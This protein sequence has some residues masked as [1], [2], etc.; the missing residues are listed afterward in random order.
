MKPSLTDLVQKLLKRNKIYF[1][2]TELEFQIQSHPSYPSLHAITG[3]LDH[4]SIENV[5]AK[6]SIDSATLQQLPNHFIAQIQESE[7]QDLV[8]V[9][10]KQSAYLVYTTTDKKQI[11][12]EDEFLKKFTGIIVAV[13]KQGNNQSLL[14][15]NSK[16]KYIAFGI[17]GLFVAFL[18]FK[19]TDSVFSICHLV[20]SIIGVVVS[21]AIV[22]QELGLQ[23]S[24]GDAFCS[25]TDDQKD[26][27]AV[28]SSKGAEIIKGYKL[29]DF[30]MLYFSVLVT[31]TFIQILNP[32]LSYSISLLTIP[33]TLYSLYYQYI[34]VK[35]WCLLCLSIIGVLWLQ[36]LISVI[37]DMYITNFVLVDFVVLGIIV[38]SIWL[39][40]SFIKP[41]IL[42][43]TTLRKDK[44][45]AIKFKRNF[46][47]F[48]GML[49][50]SHQI[51]TI[52][53]ENQEIVFGNPVSNLEIVIVTNPFCGH[54]KP[55]HQQVDEILHK[56]K[57]KVKIIIRFNINTEDEDSNVVKITC[58]MLEIYSQKGAK[59]CLQA[60]TEIY[61]NGKPDHWLKT[62]R[63]C[64]DKERFISVL[65][66]ENTWCKNNAINFTPEIL[67]NGKFYPKEYKRSDLIFF[68]EDLE[69][70]YGAVAIAQ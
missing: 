25:E 39:L 18:L 14:E 27:D 15:S 23:T 70:N 38:V 48:E 63:E 13:E 60:M 46:V 30:S 55:V 22:K 67:I 6:V 8:V 19:T 29:S 66:K 34:V 12:S 56:Y 58:R 49:N 52:I 36:A 62:W 59:E 53:D 3:V 4:F 21:I 11:L 41:L 24:I 28:L 2:R 51:D 17:L 1:D 33:I 35:K 47:L 10:K 9:E 20:L 32:V 43:I 16:R 40:W 26:C 57:G 68:I 69:E 65:E 5:A 45:E 7:K 50:K 44:I 31:L 54:C 37:T 64:T 61:E 42:E